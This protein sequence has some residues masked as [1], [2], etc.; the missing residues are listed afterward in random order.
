MC[1]GLYK[2]RAGDQPIRTPSR[3]TSVQASTLGNLIGRNAFER[4]SRQ[5]SRKRSY[6]QRLLR[7]PI[8]TP[9]RERHSKLI[10]LTNAT[11][12][13]QTKVVSDKAFLFWRLERYSALEW[14]KGPTGACSGRR[15]APARSGLF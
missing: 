6:G 11:E 1:F 9:S 4:G 2:L 5:R 10:R 3:S 12:R 14:Q 7:Q 8:R 15:L 13:M